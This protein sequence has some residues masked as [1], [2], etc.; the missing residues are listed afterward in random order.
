AWEE[1]VEVNVLGLTFG[2]A[3]KRPALKLPAVGRV[4]MP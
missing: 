2:V 1:G 4:G 3:V